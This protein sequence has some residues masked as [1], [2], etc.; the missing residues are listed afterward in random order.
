MPSF[1]SEVQKAHLLAVSA[2]VRNSLLEARHC[3]E[4]IHHRLFI[5]LAT[6]NPSSASR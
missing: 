1:K 4:E 2:A 5:V 6:R 3:L